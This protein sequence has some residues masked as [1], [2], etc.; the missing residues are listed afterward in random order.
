M[1]FIGPGKKMLCDY[2]ACVCVCVC[3]CV[4]VR[5]SMK[6]LHAMSPKMSAV[7]P[8]NIAHQLIYDIGTVKITELIP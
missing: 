2:V 3:V 6:I 7:F 4:S 8:L 1:T 5:P